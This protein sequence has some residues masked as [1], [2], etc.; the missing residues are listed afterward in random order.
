MSFTLCDVHQRRFP[1]WPALG[2]LREA[3]EAAARYTRGPTDLTILVVD[4][5][6]IVRAQAWQ[7]RTYRVK[8]CSA[9]KGSGYI[10]I[11]TGEVGISG[12]CARCGGLRW[13][14]DEN[15]VVAE[16]RA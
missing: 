15:E 14:P 11:T 2:S 8:D 5:G 9:C 6:G 4:P 16:V 10:A 13:R 3:Y 7:G 12:P 1:N